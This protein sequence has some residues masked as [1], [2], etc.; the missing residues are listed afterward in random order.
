[1]LDYVN[2]VIL[3]KPESDL[4]EDRIADIMNTTISGTHFTDIENINAVMTSSNP[5]LEFLTEF[6]A[7]T[8][9]DIKRELKAGLPV[10]VWVKPADGSNYYFHSVVVTGIDDS[11]KKISFNDPTYGKEYTIGQSEF[12]SMWE[13]SGTRMIKTK[14]GRI[15]RETLEQYM[16]DEVSNE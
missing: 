2:Q 4:D 16:S 15:S 9:D 3:T 14:I 7:H 10:S 1:M 5:S 12:M 8:L 6:E 13:F 11:K